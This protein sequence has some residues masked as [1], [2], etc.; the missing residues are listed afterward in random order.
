MRIA[1]MNK[2]LICWLTEM[3]EG[4]RTGQ[5]ERERERERDDDVACSSFQME[6]VVGV[7][8]SKASEGHVKGGRMTLAVGRSGEGGQRRANNEQELRA[9][10]VG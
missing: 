6:A 10:D 9:S 2:L 1:A 3:E 7:W 8:R 4:G 5:R